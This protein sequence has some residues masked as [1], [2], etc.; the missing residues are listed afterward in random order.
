MVWPFRW[1]QHDGSIHV[2]SS[3]VP[4]NEADRIPAAEFAGGAALA[5]PGHVHDF[6]FLVGRWRVHHR[7]LVGRLIG[8]TEWEEFAGECVMQ[9]MLG[10]QANVDDNVLYAPAGSYRA[11]TIRVFDPNTP[12]WSIYWID[13][14]YP[15]S[16]IGDPVVGGF[17]DGCGL[18]LAHSEMDGRRVLTRFIWHADGRDACRWEQAASIDGGLTWETNWYM[19]FERVSHE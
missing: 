18:F 9:K 5:P 13:S 2:M 6:D 1:C 17:A 12:A 7:R 14:R 11:M 16:M 19:D 8:S 3:P 15:P 10:G 4:R